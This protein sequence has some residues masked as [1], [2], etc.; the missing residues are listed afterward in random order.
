MQARTGQYLGGSRFAEGGAQ[1]AEPLHN[2]V[3]EIGKLVDRFAKG[4]QRIQGIVIDPANPGGNVLGRYEKVASGFNQG[5]TSCGTKFENRQTF[6][7][8]VL[9]ATMRRNLCKAFVLDAEFLTQQKNLLFEPLDFSAM[10]YGRTIG[11][12]DRAANAGGAVTNFK[13]NSP[14]LWKGR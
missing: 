13:R 7:R 4:N 12:C 10:L 11:T 9:R 5:P 14:P 6:D 1:N 2:I 8:F 3:D